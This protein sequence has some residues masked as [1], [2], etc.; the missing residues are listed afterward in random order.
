VVQ[1]GRA[2]ELDVTDGRGLAAASLP[3]GNRRI[4]LHW[5][6]MRD[7]DNLL[8]AFGAPLPDVVSAPS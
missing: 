1:R 5:R 4:T 6:G 8:F 7:S 2:S 3:A